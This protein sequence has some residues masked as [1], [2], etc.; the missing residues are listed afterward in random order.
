MDLVE[1]ARGCLLGGA[2]GDALGAGIEFDSWAA[3]RQKYGPDGVTGLVPAYGRLGA[4]TD[5]TQ[6]ALFTAEAILGTRR[7]SSTY[8]I[9]SFEE[10]LIASYRRWLATQGIAL[11]PDA[12]RVGPEEKTG[13]LWSQP[14]MHSQRA[15][16]NT[17]IQALVDD[18]FS[19]F[20]DAGKCGRMNESKGAGGIMRVAP[21]G[22]AVRDPASAFELA[23]QAAHI[24]HG[25]PT[26]FLSAGAFAYVLSS[27]GNDVLLA[28]AIEGACDFLRKKQ[29]SEE[30]LAAIAAAVNCVTRGA[31][32]DQTTLATLGE[33]WIAEEAL[34]IALYCASVSDDFRTAT[35]LSVNHSG[36]SDTTGSLV[37]ALIGI[38]H[39]EGALPPDWL[40][41]LELRGVITRI[42]EAL[43]AKVDFDDQQL[44]A[45]HAAL[46]PYC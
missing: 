11:T 2:I 45:E 19:R 28:D 16:G 34:A 14:E 43:V 3:I 37:G 42:A 26:G 8:G 35:L 24:T 12:Q 32:A 44:F 25:H 40:G 31:V 9:A 30:T 46:F 20:K 13:L 23:V 38:Q 5:D 22:I 27:L 6:M 39:G 18:Q 33:G 36:D 10:A 15:P 21:I 4:I 29:D 1:R 41:Q 17:C 7:R